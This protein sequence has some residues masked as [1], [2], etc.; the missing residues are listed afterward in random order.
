MTSVAGLACTR[1]HEVRSCLLDD[2]TLADAGALAGISA[3]ER[4][5]AWNW[6]LGELITL[7]IVGKQLRRKAI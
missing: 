1:L 4:P 6:P 7:V 3:N 2:N 5:I